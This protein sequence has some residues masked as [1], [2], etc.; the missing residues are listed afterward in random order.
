MQKNMP[1]KI[2]EAVIMTLIIISSVTLVID[3]PLTDPNSSTIVFF[4]YLDHCFTILFTL[5]ALVKIIAL[6]FIFNNAT[7]RARGLTAYLKNPW[8][9]LDF[10]VVLASVF[11]FIVTV[12]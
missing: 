7:L 8:N 11:D 9:L 3:N 2:F 5:E 6:G 4:S 1:A 12:T 10:V